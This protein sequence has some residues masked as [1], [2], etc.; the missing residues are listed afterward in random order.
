[1]E[2]CSKFSIRT[3]INRFIRIN[4]P[5]TMIKKKKI[6]AEAESVDR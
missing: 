2:T 1:M 6:V 3:D 4:C 5:K